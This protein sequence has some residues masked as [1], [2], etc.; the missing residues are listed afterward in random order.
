VVLA[1]QGVR[2]A[3]EVAAYPG[4]ICVDSP[5]GAVALTPA[6]RFGQAAPAAQAGSLAAPMPG[7]VT[8]LGAAVGDS[9]QAGQPLVWLEAMKMQHVIA[10]PAAGV[11]AE[12]PVAEGQQVEVGTVLAVVK[13]GAD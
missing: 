2:R 4:L 7:T 8:R 10:A 6:S 9:V 3:F 1:V 12:L 13:S 11:L 5:L